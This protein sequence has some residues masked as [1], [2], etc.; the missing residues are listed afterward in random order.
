M[1]EGTEKKA[2]R[3][4]IIKKEVPETAGEGN[5]EECSNHE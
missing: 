5:N 2:E 1:A 4:R 3:G